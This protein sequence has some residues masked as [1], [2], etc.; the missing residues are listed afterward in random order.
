MQK[1]SEGKKSTLLTVKR[2]GNRGESPCEDA[3]DILQEILNYDSNLRNWFDRD[4]YFE[5]GSD[6]S[7]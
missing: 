3:L 6:L 2:F 4:L 5:V 7:V 1:G